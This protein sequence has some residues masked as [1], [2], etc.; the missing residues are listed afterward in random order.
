MEKNKIVFNISKKNFILF[1]RSPMIEFYNL[2]T[3]EI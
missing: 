3:N 2:S 1:L